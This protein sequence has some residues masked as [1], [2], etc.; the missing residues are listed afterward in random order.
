MNFNYITSVLPSQILVTE[1]WKPQSPEDP[2]PLIIIFKRGVPKATRDFTQG[3]ALEG[4]SMK[5]PHSDW[6]RRLSHSA[7]WHSVTP[8]SHSLGC[9]NSRGLSPIILW[10]WD[11]VTG[12]I[13]PAGHWRCLP[14]VL[15]PCHQVTGR[16]TPYLSW[17]TEHARSFCSWHPSVLEINLVGTLS[18]KRPFCLSLLS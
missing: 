15:P 17:Y 18:Y 14:F 12:P 2:D 4:F 3:L 11:P 10:L 8:Q 1:N 13:F 6:K 16:C 9:P 5:T 7:L